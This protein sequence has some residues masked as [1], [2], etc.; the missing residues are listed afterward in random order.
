MK[1]KSIQISKIAKELEI[2]SQKVLD[3]LR[4]E[5]PDVDISKGII[6]KIDEKTYSIILKKFDPDGYKTY[7]EKSSET[8][9]DRITSAQKKQIDIKSRIPEIEEILSSK[10]DEVEEDASSKKRTRRKIKGDEPEKS[11]SQAEEAPETITEE[12]KEEAPVPETVP[13]A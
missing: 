12:P 3:F 9:D 8:D 1:G 13:S 6:A 10:R 11:V 5:C 4:G 2:S 7:N